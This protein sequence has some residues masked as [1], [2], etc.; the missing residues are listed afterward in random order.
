MAQYVCTCMCVLV[1]RE[2]YRT[3]T[4]DISVRNA[5]RL[6]QFGEE[7]GAIRPNSRLMDGCQWSNVIDRCWKN[8]SPIVCSILPHNSNPL[9]KF[10]M[11]VQ[12]QIIDFNNLSRNRHCRPNGCWARVHLVELKQRLALALSFEQLWRLF[13]SIMLLPLYSQMCLW[14]SDT[15]SLS[16][17]LLFWH[18]WTG[19]FSA[20]DLML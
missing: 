13:S 11:W 5:Y 2:T 10:R 12:R 3:L 14:T 7:I 6:I 20:W 19:C 4:T 8:S 17:A 1:C 15:F 9:D 16:L 18:C